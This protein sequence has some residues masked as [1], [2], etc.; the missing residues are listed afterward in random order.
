MDWY[1]SKSRVRGLFNI[2]P[3]V[4]M[5]LSKEKKKGSE[6]A[7][8]RKYI[9]PYGITKRAICCIKPFS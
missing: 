3:S 6:Y 8:G 4:T 1:G 7:L 9:E 5:N 2:H